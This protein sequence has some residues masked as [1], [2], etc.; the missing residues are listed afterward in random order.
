MTPQER[1]RKSPKGRAAQEAGRKRYRATLQGA[2]ANQGS[3]LRQRY[4]IGLEEFET[5][6]VE[7]G[8]RCAACGR[9]DRRLIVDHDHATGVVRGLVCA[10]CNR[11]VS[12]LESP[13]R[14]VCEEYLAAWQ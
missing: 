3:R 11:V 4:G 1:Y 8:G 12:G 5:M 7:Q 10:S 2:R 13:S 14:D 9:S 6:L